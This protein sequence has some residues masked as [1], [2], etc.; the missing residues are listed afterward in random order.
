[1]FFKSADEAGIDGLVD[2]E[3]RESIKTFDPVVGG[4]A[5]AESLA[6]DVVAGKF[7]LTAVIDAGVAVDV[8]GGGG[9]RIVLHPVL[10]ELGGPCFAVAGGTN[11]ATGCGVFSAALALGDWRSGG[12]A[13]SGGVVA[14]KVWGGGL[15]REWFSVVR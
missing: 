3:K 1:L 9:G 2:F 12:G 13:G 11:A 14:R 10:A 6:G 15:A 7:G 4:G 5:Q 8:E